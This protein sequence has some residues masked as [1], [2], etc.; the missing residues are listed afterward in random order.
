MDTSYADVSFSAANT[1]CGTLTIW[2]ATHDAILAHERQHESG[3]NNC[4]SG[5]AA[6]S[7]MSEIE[8]L[9]GSWNDIHMRREKAWDDFHSNTQYGFKGSGSWADPFTSGGHYH[10][11]NG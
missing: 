10:Y 7:V 3:Y 1:V 5:M 8:K 9:T 6:Q 2:N 11:E 4:L